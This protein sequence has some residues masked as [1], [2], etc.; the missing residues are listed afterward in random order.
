[1]ATFKERVEDRIGSIS[2]DNALSD[3]LTAG[4]R[5]ITNILPPSRV[6]K[7]TTDLIDAGLGISVTTVR[8]LRA[9][10]E[11]YNAR[12]IDAG[13]A[14]KIADAASI[15]Y[16]N[17]TDP[18]WY[19]SNGLG[20]V[21]PSGGT[22]VGMAY[23]TVLYSAST[24]NN[25]PVDLDEGV[26]LYASIQGTLRQMSTLTTSTLGGLSIT[27]IMPPS[28]P[29]A[30]SVSYT[31]T[32]AA[33]TNQDIELSSGHLNKVQTQISEYGAKLQ[34]YGADIS[35]YSNKIQEEA[36]RLSTRINQYNS[37][38]QQYNGSL[39]AL[40]IEFADFIKSIQ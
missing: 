12:R 29:S 3:W 40:K 25:F 38:Y 16:A 22:I 18:A 33:L 31:N 24:I 32:D 21:I 7:Y 27:T 5:F 34:L 20:F 13:L 1:M 17:T 4:A 36:A 30:I 19:V 8:I 2:D 14:A 35:V 11:G 6:E 10:K 26:V 28:A 15:H 39:Q 23:P 37:Q 9:H